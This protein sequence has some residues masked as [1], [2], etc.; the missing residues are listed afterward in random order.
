MACKGAAPSIRSSSS[1]ITAPALCT[2]APNYTTAPN[3]TTPKGRR[4]CMHHPQPTASHP[5]AAIRG[6]QTSSSTPCPTRPECRANTPRMQSKHAQN[7]HLQ[8]VA[9]R[10]GWHHPQRQVQPRAGRQV[11]SVTGWVDHRAHTCREVDWVGWQGA[12]VLELQACLGC[13]CQSAWLARRT[14]PL[15]ACAHTQGD[16]KEQAAGRA[17]AGL[18]ASRQDLHASVA[19]NPPVQ[20]CTWGAQ[21]RISPQPEQPF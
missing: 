10:H 9:A 11:C 18:H 3:C 7:P 8:H 6:K 13:C 21:G 17:W 16:T 2:T 5:T 19:L 1:L 20:R 15:A 4:P 14:H 12:G